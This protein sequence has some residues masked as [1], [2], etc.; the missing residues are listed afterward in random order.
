[1]NTFFPFGSSKI[2]KH[3]DMMAFH[4]WKICFK[5]VTVANHSVQTEV[6]A[7]VAGITHQ[8]QLSFFAQSEFNHLHNTYI[9][10]FS[11]F[12]HFHLHNIFNRCIF[13]LH[14]NI[15]RIKTSLCVRDVI[16]L[17][18][19]SF[20]LIQMIWFCKFV[21]ILW[22]TCLRVSSFTHTKVKE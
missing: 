14:L 12:Y 20:M 5:I 2:L 9:M 4:D 10:I 8:T 11:F 16:N 7:T 13:M 21:S 22:D 6:F 17:F 15:W 18:P 1:M 3:I 19:C